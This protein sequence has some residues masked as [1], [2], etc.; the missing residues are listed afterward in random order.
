[1]KRVLISRKTESILGSILIFTAITYKVLI[2][3]NLINNTILKYDIYNSVIALLFVCFIFFTENKEKKKLW[4]LFVCFVV[5][6][7]IAW[8][9]NNCMKKYKNWSYVQF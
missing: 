6:L 3:I 5:A 9:R 2:Y 8:Y 7:I 1:M 4:V